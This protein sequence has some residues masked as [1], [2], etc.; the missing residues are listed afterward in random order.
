MLV[1][2]KWVSNIFIPD[3]AGISPLM[4][5]LCIDFASV[6][7]DQYLVATSGSNDIWGRTR[8][9]S[10]NKSR[11]SHSSGMAVDIAPISSRQG[12]TWKNVKSPRLCDNVRISSALASGSPTIAIFLEDDHFHLDLTYQPGVYLAVQRSPVLGEV[13]FSVREQARTSGRRHIFKV[14]PDGTVTPISLSSIS[15]R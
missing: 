10:E 13:P 5:R 4:E 9:S 7:P 12:V 2:G 14:S 11:R 6:L 1:S 3:L 8:E 15:L